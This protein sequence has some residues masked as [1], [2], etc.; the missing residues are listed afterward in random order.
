MQL[1]EMIDEEM[2]HVAIREMGKIEK[3]LGICIGF[4]KCHETVNID[5]LVST[6]RIRRGIFFLNSEISYQNSIL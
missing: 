2:S 3:Y 1:I 4:N 6:L 5:R